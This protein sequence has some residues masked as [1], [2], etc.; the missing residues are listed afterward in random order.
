MCARCWASLG[1]PEDVYEAHHRM[2]R[3]DL[4]GWCV[5]NIVILHPR[6]H[7]QGPLAVHDHPLEAKKLGLIVEP[8][9]DPREVPLWVEWPWENHSLLD[10]ESQVVSML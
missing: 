8:W 9:L 7:T 5:C 2:R 6:C 3:R 4:P 10:C 1:S